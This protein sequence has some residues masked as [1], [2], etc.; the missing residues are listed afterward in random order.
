MREEALTNRV[1]ENMIRLED[2][3]YEQS[4][5]EK[6]I[7]DCVERISEPRTAFVSCCERPMHEDEPTVAGIAVRGP[8]RGRRCLRDC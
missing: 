1:M 7:L 8:D 4:T 5:M 2:G 3:D 6:F